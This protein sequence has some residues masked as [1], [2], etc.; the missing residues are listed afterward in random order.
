MLRLRLPAKDVRRAVK[1]VIDA[2]QAVS[3]F[4]DNELWCIKT[5]DREYKACI[6]HFSSHGTEALL[7]AVGIVLQPGS[8]GSSRVL[9]ARTSPSGSRP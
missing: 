1:F 5:S 2:L 4:P 3:R 6:K 8:D 9:A 7:D